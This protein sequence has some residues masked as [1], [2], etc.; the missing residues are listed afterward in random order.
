[1]HSQM[2]ARYDESLPP[3][4]NRSYDYIPRPVRHWPPVGHELMKHWIYCPKRVRGSTI[5]LERFPKHCAK[6]L[7]QGN[8]RDDVVGWGLELVEGRD[9]KFLFVPLLMIL[10]L[11]TTFGVAWAHFMNDISGGFTV[12]SYM[13][14]AF[15]LVLGTIE[16]VWDYV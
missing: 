3:S 6:E 7:A 12:A 4:S 9:W 11:S 5:C 8:S 10:V 13:V 16:V 1:M 14:T 2:D 15:T